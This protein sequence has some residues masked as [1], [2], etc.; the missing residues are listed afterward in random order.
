MIYHIKNDLKVFS[1]KINETNKIFIKNSFLKEI[2]TKF[3]FDFYKLL[4]RFDL[5]TIK[6]LLFH[7]FY[8]YKID[9]VNN[10]HT[11]QNRIYFLF[12]LK[13]MKLKKYLKKNLMKIFINLNNILFF[14]LILFVIK[15]NKEF[16]FYVNYRKC[17]VIIKRN[18]YFIF[19]IDKILI[20]LI[21]YKNI[22]KLN[23]IA[24][25]N[26]L[27]M[28]S[29]NENLITFICLLKVY[30]YHVLFFDLTNDFSNYQHYINDILF[31]FLNEFVQCYLNDILIYN[32]IRKKYIYYI[33]LILQKLIDTNL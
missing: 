21:K 12:Y 19:L 8:D 11:M 17:N 18:D 29:K 33:R 32:K 7:Y 9:F 27:Q 20:K 24:A 2:K 10:F 1:S 30:K 13:L 15:F 6:N 4:Q 14:S 26:K 3:H 22:T 25:F 16:Y 28:H 31:D 23:I 5:I